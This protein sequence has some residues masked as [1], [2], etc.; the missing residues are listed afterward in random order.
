MNTSFATYGLVAL[1]VG[2][3][4]FTA[5]SD[6]EASGNCP[7]GWESDLVPQ[8]PDDPD[9][10]NFG[11]YGC[12]V[13]HGNLDMRE[14]SGPVWPRAL[15]RIKQVDGTIYIGN[16]KSGTGVRR[17]S[18]PRLEVI[19]DGS[20]TT[21]EIKGLVIDN[22]NVVERIED[23]PALQNTDGSIYIRNTDALESVGSFPKLKQAHHIAFTQN[24]ALKDMGAFSSLEELTGSLSFSQNT[25]LLNT[26]TWN[27]LQR[28]ETGVS[29]EQNNLL[30]TTGGFPLLESIGDSLIWKQNDSLQTIADL[31]Q[32]VDLKT[33]E[34][35]DNKLL[36]SPPDL[37]GLRNV[38]VRLSIRNN[39]N[40]PAMPG[41]KALDGVNAFEVINN[42]ILPWGFVQRI[43]DKITIT[44]TDEALV[45]GNK[46]QE[47][48][49]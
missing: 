16:G 34:L 21:A 43:V 40:L 7:D 10:N 5:C 4:L 20:N 49:K 26:P 42:P 3:A 47:A 24:T 37:N 39:S 18:F 15:E 13:I 6:D 27:L 44:G 2:A 38:T 46:T 48:C 35:A 41:F 31:P 9:L 17:V 14:F 8:G 30:K 33:L 22:D 32:L 36:T 45:C 11:R 25:I 12:E 28:I 23:F 29:F 19:G 1:C